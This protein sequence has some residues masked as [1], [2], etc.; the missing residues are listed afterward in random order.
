[1]CLPVFTCNTTAPSDQLALTI[2]REGEPAM[3]FIA[4]SVANTGNSCSSVQNNA[5]FISDSDLNDGP[6]F[7]ILPLSDL[8]SKQPRFYISNDENGTNI[9]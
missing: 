3:P 4:S 9:P 7:A 5:L 1:M 2:Y 6:V 8:N